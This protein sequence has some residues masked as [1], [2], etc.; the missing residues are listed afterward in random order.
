MFCLA[1]TA[2]PSTEGFFEWMWTV[3][4][5]NELF[6]SSRDGQHQLLIVLPFSSLLPRRAPA[7]RRLPLPGEAWGGSLRN[8]DFTSHLRFKHRLC[9]GRPSLVAQ[10]NRKKLATSVILPGY[11]DLA[12]RMDS[13]SDIEI[14]PSQP[15]QATKKTSWKPRRPVQE[16][17]PSLS[18]LPLPKTLKR[19]AEKT[20]NSDPSSHADSDEDC[21]RS[22]KRNLQSASTRPKGPPSS[23]SSSPLPSSPELPHLPRRSP[24]PALPDP[25]PLPPTRN[26]RVKDRQE[27]NKSR[28]SSPPPDKRSAIIELG[29]SPLLPDLED[30]NFGGNRNPSP[31]NPLP[32]RQSSS[33]PSPPPTSA[34]ISKA[35]TNRTEKQAQAAQARLLRE[36]KKAA[37]EKEKL[38]NRLQREANKLTLNRKETVAEVRMWVPK[39]LKK[40]KLHPFAKACEVLEQRIASTEGCVM[41]PPG[42]IDDESSELQGVVRWVRTAT[43]EWDEERGIFIPLGVG[44][45]KETSEP[46]VLVV[47][48]GKEVDEVIASGTDQLMKKAQVIKSHYPQDQLFIVIS[49]LETILRAERRNEDAMIT[50]EARERLAAQRNEP[51]PCAPKTKSKSGSALPRNSR[52]KI[53]KELEVMKLVTK[54]FVIRVEEKNE[55]ANWLWEMTM[56]IGVRPYKSRK[57]ELK[58]ALRLEVSGTKG[59]NYEDTYIKMLSSLTRVTENEA[60]G[61]VA[62]FPT[63]RCL[64]QAWE[65]GIQKHGVQWAEDMLVGC[66]K[67]NAVTAVNSNRKIGKVTSKRIF[68]IMYNTKNGDACL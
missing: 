42:E 43:K 53:L 57:Q 15:A 37:K 21:E 20:I 23:H 18:P 28:P 60:K 45:S 46:T 51:P 26:P 58:S 7:A 9:P 39:S 25:L 13:D 66:S 16:K 36:A 54:A 68:E 2:C 33:H 17:L 22:T 32:S 55:F 27:T 5:P 62:K 64:Y 52:D 41:N 61:I 34:P 67:S 10:D 50:N 56:E 63:L 30:F 14:V 3:W 4:P 65:Q 29:S 38:D 49:G 11:G 6:L 12:R 8:C 40:S 1:A 35:T 31:P 48:T 44:Q 47:W 59:T 24:S 19:P